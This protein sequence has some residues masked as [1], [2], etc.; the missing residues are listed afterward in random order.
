M[1]LFQM[2]VPKKKENLTMVRQ[3]SNP[4]TQEAEAGGVCEF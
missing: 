3:V 1:G 2:R 4:S